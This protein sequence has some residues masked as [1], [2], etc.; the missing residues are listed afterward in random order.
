[1]ERR[2]DKIGQTVTPVCNSG[3]VYNDTVDV[4]SKRASVGVVDIAYEKPG[5]RLWK[6][7]SR[8]QPGRTLIRKTR[9][10][11]AVV[12]CGVRTGSNWIR[13][14]SDSEWLRPGG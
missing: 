3:A 13:R 4:L 11:A 2:R 5:A 12:N 10:S 7:V 8:Y 1:M 14:A 6:A 9:K